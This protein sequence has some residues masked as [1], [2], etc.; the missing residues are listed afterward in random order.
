MNGKPLEAT[1]GSDGP[2]SCPADSEGE[3]NEGW[4]CNTAV[5]W[6]S[7]SQSLE[8]SVLSLDKLETGLSFVERVEHSRRR[9]EVLSLLVDAFLA[10]FNAERALWPPPIAF[11]P[12]SPTC[13]ASE[14]A[15]SSLRLVGPERVRIHCL[16]ERFRSDSVKGVRRP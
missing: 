16:C 7:C 10:S 6:S 15:P 8:S 11:R 1:E 9:G 2:G 5:M 3:F 4:P 13:V 14:S 12:P